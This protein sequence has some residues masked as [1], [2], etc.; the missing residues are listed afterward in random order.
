MRGRPG[1]PAPQVILV[2]AGVYMRVE[3]LDNSQQLM[4][5][6]RDG[7][8]LDMMMDRLLLSGDQDQRK[9]DAEQMAD[10]VN[11]LA[12]WQF[13]A[14]LTW[15]DWIDDKGVPHGI[16]VEGARK[17]FEK[18]MRRELPRVS[19]FYAVEPN[20]SRDGSH[21]HAL[22]CDLGSVLTWRTKSGELLRAAV[23]PDGPV[24][25]WS[26][27]FGRFGRAKITRVRNHQDVTNYC[28]KHLASSYVTKGAVWWNVKLQ[29]HRIQAMNNSDFKLRPEATLGYERTIAG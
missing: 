19:Y 3:Q 25:P 7:R 26:S 9:I 15:K 2:P 13:I 20:P 14:D 22:W 24:D 4:F 27:W 29:W 28:A 6:K 5:R 18:F 23:G 12:P 16:T 10:W 17:C 1:G 8:V 21:V 11:W